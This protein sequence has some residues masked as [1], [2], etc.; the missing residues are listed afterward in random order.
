MTRS[1]RDDTDEHVPLDLTSGV[2]HSP[3]FTSIFCTKSYTMLEKT[4]SLT[5]GKSRS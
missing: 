1:I 3:S 2:S 4:N 5:S